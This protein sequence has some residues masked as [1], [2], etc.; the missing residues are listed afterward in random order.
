MDNVNDFKDISFIVHCRIDNKER[1]K[2]A[3]LV[4]NF[5]KSNAVNCEFIFIEDD[6]EDKLSQYITIDDLDQHITIGNT[7]DWPIT[8]SNWHKTKCYNIGAKASNRNY[9]CFLDLDVIVHPKHILQAVEQIKCNKSN[10][11]IGY[12]GQTLYLTYDAKR[13]FSDN[14]TYT[15]LLYLKLES[16]IPQNWLFEGRLLNSNIKNVQNHNTSKTGSPLNIY[17]YCM[18]PNTTAV[19]G[20]VIAD[21]KSFFEYK[22]FN[23]NFIGWGYEDGELTVRVHKLGYKVHKINCAEALLFHLPHDPV[24]GDPNKKEYIKTWKL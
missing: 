8:D 9:F 10:L 5:Y 3:S 15:F 24:G 6:I 23:P 11:V 20:C 7:G 12:N 17:E 13:L 21:K 18:A 22:G 1:A 4:Y 19:G 16:F 2:N 14:P